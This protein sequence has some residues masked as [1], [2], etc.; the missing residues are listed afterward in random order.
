MYLNMLI[1]MYIYDMAHD[2]MSIIVVIMNRR[3]SEKYS[4]TGYCTN[5]YS[6]RYHIIKYREIRNND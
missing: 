4:H 6:W 5:T 1:I 2:T 3:M